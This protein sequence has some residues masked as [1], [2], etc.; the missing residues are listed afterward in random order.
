[1]ETIELVA[2]F[3]KHSILHLLYNL[4]VLSKEGNLPVKNTFVRKDLPPAYKETYKNKY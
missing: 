2:K 3:K 1:M 4:V